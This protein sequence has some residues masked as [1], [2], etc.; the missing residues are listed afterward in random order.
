[1]FRP[2]SLSRRLALALFFVLLAS[3]CFAAQAPRNVIFF[4]GD[5]M[6][7]GQLT[8]ARLAA[9][10]E[11]KFALD[12]MP[13]VGLV[14]TQ[15][16]NMVVTDSAAAATALA[17]GSKT[18]NGRIAVLPDGTKLSTICE[19][20][21]D[22]GKSVGLVTTDTVTGATPAGFVAHV[23]SRKQEQ[24]IATQML[25][26][27]PDV[28]LGGGRRQFLPTDAGGKRIDGRNLVIE[29]KEMGY[30]AVEDEAQL[31]AAKSPKLLGL[32]ANDIM[33]DPAAGPSLSQMTLKAIS[34]LKQ[35]K[36]GYFLMSEQA[37]T[38]KC[39]HANNSASVVDAVR[40]LDDALRAAVELAAKDKDTLILVTADHET[41]GLAMKDPAEANARFKA[42]WIDGNHTG[43]MVAIFAF[44]PGSELFAGIHDNTDIP[45]LIAKLWGKT[46]NN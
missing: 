4:I 34:A 3:S 41:G 46:I 36:R 20:A 40:K 23:P 17:T 24:D 42:A 10:L 6:G 19:L 1:M 12:S 11:T 18:E 38:D 5:G 33:S 27:K 8:S 14:T 44:G 9:G 22:L 29:A 21:R 37:L 32:F 28:I 30:E 15:P 13:V 31:N 45:K 43:N 26:F 7:I 16:L 39:S 35:N 25:A 2:Q